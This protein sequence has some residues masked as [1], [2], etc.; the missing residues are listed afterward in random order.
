MRN[1]GERSRMDKDLGRPE[2]RRAGGGGV[3]QDGEPPGLKAVKN[4][5]GDAVALR[6]PYRCALERLHEGGHHRVLHEDRERASD[7]Q[8]NRSHW[9]ALLVGGDHNLVHARSHVCQVVSQG[10]DGHQLAGDGN[11]KLV[12][13]RK[14]RSSARQP[15]RTQ[16]P[17]GR[18]ANT[19]VV[20]EWPCSVGACPTVI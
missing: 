3:G 17:V 11:V 10:Q 16:P 8:V 19:C 7:T 12:P 14:P 6:T 15:P 5:R 18:A 4:K 9:S 20:R 1:V 2:W 13:G